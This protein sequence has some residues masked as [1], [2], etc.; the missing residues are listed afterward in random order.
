MQD[1]TGSAYYLY[2]DNDLETIDVYQETAAHGP[3]ATPTE[4]VPEYE[5]KIYTTWTTWS[6]CSMCDSVGIKLR[7]GYCT[8][9]LLETAATHDKY[10]ISEDVSTTD[11]LRYTKKTGKRK[12]KTNNKYSLAFFNS[13]PILS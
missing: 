13:Y 10:M 11:K 6:S 4:N 12:D 8:I 2:I 3:Q 7:Y 9:S 1:T 5:L